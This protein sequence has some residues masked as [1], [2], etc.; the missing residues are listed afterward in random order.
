VARSESNL[1]IIG[2]TL[3]MYADDHEGHYPPDL[4]ALFDAGFLDDDKN[5]IDP[6]DTDPQKDQK[7]GRP[8]SYVYAGTLPPKLPPN[9][10][11]CY[12]RKGIHKGLRVVLYADGAVATVSED[13]LHKPGAARGMSLWDCYRWAADNWPGELVY[14]NDARL[15]EFFEVAD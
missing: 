10:I 1:R 2:L 6:A 13:D 15:Q 3:Q 14:D 12:S 5:L 9:F 4:A 11:V 8:C 7:S